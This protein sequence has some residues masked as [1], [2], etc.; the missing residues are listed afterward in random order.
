MILIGGWVMLVR[1]SYEGG[2]G[3]RQDSWMA[4]SIPQTKTKSLMENEQSLSLSD[5]ARYML[6]SQMGFNY[7]YH[8]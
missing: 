1:L 5:K 4:V 6:V 7:K 8:F 3:G 2:P